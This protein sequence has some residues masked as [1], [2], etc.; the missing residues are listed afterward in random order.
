LPL[1]PLP[2]RRP[3]RARITQCSC[4]T[5]KRWPR[6]WPRKDCLSW[7]KPLAPGRRGACR[8]R[9][10]RFRTTTCRA[11]RHRRAGCRCQAKPRAPGH[12]IKFLCFLF[13]LNY[14]WCV[15][16][17]VI[18]ELLHCC[19]MWNSQNNK[20]KIVGKGKVGAEWGIVGWAPP[21]QQ[22]KLNGHEIGFPLGDA[23]R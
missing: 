7:V 17:W 2:C 9:L 12:R 11:F 10:S 21:G 4:S 23:L 19:L 8:L 18:L 6:L 14:V 1:L 22:T 13:F 16:L 15:K 5:T 20:G 3:R